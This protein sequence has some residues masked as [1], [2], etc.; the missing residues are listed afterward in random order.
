MVVIFTS[1]QYRN[2]IFWSNITSNPFCNVCLRERGGQNVDFKY[3]V[4]SETNTC[5]TTS[6][7]KWST[8]PL[9]LIS[10]SGNYKASQF[11]CSYIYE[12]SYSNHWPY[13][14]TVHMYVVIHC[15]DSML[16]QICADF[17]FCNLLIYVLPLDNQLS[18][19]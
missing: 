14:C 11:F 19:E 10:H 3:F 5:L 15:C 9:K 16:K 12:H 2:N 13:H 17:L 4:T 6:G 7:W 1:K 8:L 18:R